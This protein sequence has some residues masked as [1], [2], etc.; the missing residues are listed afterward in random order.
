MSDVTTVL[1]VHARW[2]VLIQGALEGPTPCH[3][4]PSTSV[5]DSS[6]RLSVGQKLSSTGHYMNVV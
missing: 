6:G 4:K 3:F 2:T 5:E 1:P